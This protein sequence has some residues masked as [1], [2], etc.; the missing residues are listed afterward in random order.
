MAVFHGP[1]SDGCL[2]ARGRAGAL[3]L[4][5]NAGPHLNETEHTGNSNSYVLLKY[6]IFDISSKI[7]LKYKTNINLYFNSR[8]LQYLGLLC[9]CLVS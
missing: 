3:N 4:T 6:W 2:A 5:V 7:L 1:G 8:K 9:I